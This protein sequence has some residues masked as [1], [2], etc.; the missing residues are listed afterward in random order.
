M[1]WLMTSPGP[2]KVSVYDPV[3]GA[4]LHGFN[5]PGVGTIAGIKRSSRRLDGEPQ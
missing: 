4:F 1:A 5:N 2:G 3:T